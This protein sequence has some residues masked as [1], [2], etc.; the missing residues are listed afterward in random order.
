MHDHRPTS[1]RLLQ[2]LIEPLEPDT[3]CVG[4]VDRITGFVSG[5]GNGDELYHDTVVLERVVHLVRVGDEHAGVTGV[6]EDQRGCRD[7]ARIGDRRL[8]PVG[9]RELLL[10]RRATPSEA[11]R[12]IVIR[13][14]VCV[15]P[16]VRSGAGN[17]RLPNMV[18][19]NQPGR[20]VAAIGP[21]GNG[22]PRFVD[23]ALLFKRGD[24]GQSVAAGAV[25]PIVHDSALV[26]VAEAVA[27][28]IVWPKD[29]VAPS[30]HEMWK[31]SKSVVEAH[32]G[33]P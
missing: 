33:P 22:D 11:L 6:V 17:S 5:R 26:L 19:A 10:P 25:T 24:S 7:G 3:V 28:A 9:F 23:E 2:I 14:I 1:R 29:S 8:F 32:C 21:S 18:V 12:N 13:E 4:L 15:D 31:K 20:H 27:A 30:R 16:T